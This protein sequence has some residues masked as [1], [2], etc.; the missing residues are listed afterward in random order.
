MKAFFV[1]ALVLVVSLFVADFAMAKDLV[2]AAQS[3]QSMFNR[4]GVAAIGI[5]ITVGGITFA[6]GL[7]QIG[8]M[9]L[10]SGLVGAVCVLGGPALVTLLEF[11]ASQCRSMNRA[12]LL[13]C[14]VNSFVAT[15]L[16]RTPHFIIH[17]TPC[18]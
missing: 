6:L 2:D 12:H 16:F 14:K 13:R 15:Y 18:I 7:A 3:A 10:I 1:V 8:R 11:S 9:I 5:G 17:L 4:I